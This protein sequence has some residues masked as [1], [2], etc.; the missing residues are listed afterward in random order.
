MSETSFTEEQE[1]SLLRLYQ[2]IGEA[3]RDCGKIQLYIEDSEIIAEYEKLYD[4]KK[5]FLFDAFMDFEYEKALVS[6]PK[7]ASKIVALSVAT[8]WKQTATLEELQA[9]IDQI[10]KCYPREY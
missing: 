6:Q 3:G 5:G 7:D 2:D 8:V 4:L 1:I 10:R 9:I